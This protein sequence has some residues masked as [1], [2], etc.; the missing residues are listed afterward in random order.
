LAEENIEA[1][2]IWKP[3]HLQPLWRHAER[4]GGEVAADLFARGIC[5]PSSSS[6][7][8]EQQHRVVDVV[9]RQ[10]QKAF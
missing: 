5:L 8:A 4:M 9:R 7:T 10:H 6:L 3:M 2:P 1:R